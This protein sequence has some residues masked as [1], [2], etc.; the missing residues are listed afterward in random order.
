[1]RRLLLVSPLVVL[2]LVLLPASPAQ[3]SC[4]MRDART[5]LAGSDAAFVGTYVERRGPHWVFAVEQVVQGELGPEVLVLAPAEGRISSIDLQPVP[6]RRI[7]L[8]LR[9]APAGWFTNACDEMD[10]EALL[11]TGGRPCAAPEVVSLRRLSAARAGRPVRISVRVRAA[12]D[13]AHLVRVAW[14]DG[15]SSSVALRAGDDGAVLRHRFGPARRRE[16]TARVETVRFGGCGDVVLRSEAAR[17]AFRVSR[18]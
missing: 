5:I 18:G 14:G 10:P 11:A 8:G 4:A 15:T 13:A 17:L 2:A 1:M 12:A 6:G 3:A 16:V 9:I 7:A